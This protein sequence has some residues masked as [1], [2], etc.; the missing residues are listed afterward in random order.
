MI[1]LAILKHAARL[2]VLVA[3]VVL[4]IAYVDHR[5]EQRK[6]RHYQAWQVIDLAQGK[7]GSGGRIGALQDLAEDGVSLAGI[8]V[9]GA[10]LHQIRLTGADLD[11]ANLTKADLTEA[12]LEGAFLQDAHLY[13]ANLAGPT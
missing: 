4:L 2:S 13:Q 12:N 10:W 3:V 9:S 7:P 5:E 1:F 8:D 6:A 11:D